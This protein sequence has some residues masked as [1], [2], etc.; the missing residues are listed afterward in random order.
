MKQSNTTSSLGAPDVGN[1]PQV[2]AP[3]QSLSVV[4][5]LYACV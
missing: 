2:F 3:R 1:H 4:R 5:W